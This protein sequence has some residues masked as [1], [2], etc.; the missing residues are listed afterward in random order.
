MMSGRPTS[1]L[2]A[3]RNKDNA[4]SH[5]A[6]WNARASCMQARVMLNRPS[7]A[8]GARCALDRT[9]PRIGPPA[10]PTAQGPATA[11]RPLPPPAHEPGTL[12][13][14]AAARSRHTSL[15]PAS[16]AASPCP[17]R[18]RCRRPPHPY[19]QAVQR[20][21]PAARSAALAATAS[22][23]RS[24]AAASARTAA[25]D[26]VGRARPLA[27]SRRGPRKQPRSLQ[28]ALYGHRHA[29]ASS[30]EDAGLHIGGRPAS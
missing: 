14:V 18:R 23:Q 6:R 29:P 12:G 10:S 20:K 27:C 8:T 9:H 19:A 28:P 25:T 24:S 30:I 16:Q 11:H 1:V 21:L 5:A 4:R 17:S 2:A 13:A 3:K 7:N 22:C 15:T 26:R